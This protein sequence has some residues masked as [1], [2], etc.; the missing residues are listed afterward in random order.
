M[1]LRFGLIHTHAQL[2][3]GIVELGAGVAGGCLQ[4][5]LSIGR[6]GLDIR[7]NTITM[8]NRVVCALQLL[9]TQTQ[10]YDEELLSSARAIGSRER[11]RFTWAR[12]ATTGLR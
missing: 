6:Q 2:G 3:T 8:G 10:P 11:A 5:C 7:R 4:Q 1:R 9:T 12:A